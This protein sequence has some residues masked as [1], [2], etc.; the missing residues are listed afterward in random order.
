MKGLLSYYEFFYSSTKLKYFLNGIVI[1]RIYT[2]VVKF[3]MVY[4][5]GKLNILCFYLYFYENAISMTTIIKYLHF[6]VC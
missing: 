3:G 1:V 6:D 4:D 2:T 5:E